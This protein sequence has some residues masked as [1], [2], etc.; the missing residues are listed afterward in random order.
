MTG[1]TSLASFI[2]I[3]ALA[4]LMLV[5]AGVS[6]A[7]PTL[8]DSVDVPVPANLRP[9]LLAAAKDIPKPYY[10]GCHLSATDV[11]IVP[12]ASCLYGDLA[13]SVTIDLFGDSHALT[14]F[15]AIEAMAIHEG[16]RLHVFTRST[17]SPADIPIWN[18]NTGRV[19]TE[20]AT[21]RRWAISQI[22]DE[23]PSIVFVTGTRGFETVDAQNR[24]ITGA[25]RNAIW[26]AGETRTLDSLIPSVSRVIVIGDTP[27]A[28]QSPPVCLTAHPS[29]ILACA[30]PVT[31]AINT[32]W[33]ALEKS[34]ADTVWAGFIDPALWVCPT[35]PCP[36][37]LGRTLLY[38]DGGHLTATFIR[39]L[40]SK[41][42]TVVIADL[43][44]NLGI[45]SFE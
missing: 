30:T 19:V 31:A 32:T 38:R 29:S 7:S 17:C 20:C 1:K 43:Q 33:T 42:D 25:A 45:A 44:T 4:G 15:P 11:R 3:F 2:A 28:T 6:G 9:T 18:P 23:G 13:S 10:D 27:L 35:G 22:M 8:P 21:W 16:W 5:P 34:V 12:K 40:W 24:V 14:W 26:K 41:F 39:T 36:V 37:V